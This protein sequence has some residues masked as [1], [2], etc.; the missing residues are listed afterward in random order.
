[1]IWV[2]TD[3]LYPNHLDSKVQNARQCS[4]QIFV[5][6]ET[7]TKGIFIIEIPVKYL[8][9][10]IKFGLPFLKF[11]TLFC[12]IYILVKCFLVYMTELLQLLVAPVQHFV[13][14]FYIPS[15]MPVVCNEERKRNQIKLAKTI[16]QRKWYMAMQQAINCNSIGIC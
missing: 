1:M 5:S 6:L 2:I 4:H 12:K 3:Q 10:C 9:P 14:I 16:A 13:Q 11:F 7:I 8:I 15:S